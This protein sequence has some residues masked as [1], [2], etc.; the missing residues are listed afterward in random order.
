ME[1]D[2]YRFV[3][4]VK[5]NLRS[6]VF[7]DRRVPF[8]ET[9][10][11]LPTD[12]LLRHD[13]RILDPSTAAQP[14]L[15]RRQVDNKDLGKTVRPGSRTS[16]PLMSAIRFSPRRRGGAQTGFASSPRAQRG[17]AE[18]AELPER[19]GRAPA[20]RAGRSR[21]DR[22]ARSL[23][24]PSCRPP[25]HR[26]R[27][28]DAASRLADRTNP[29]RQPAPAAG[30]LGGRPASAGRSGRFS[31]RDRPESPDVRL[32]AGRC[33]IHRRALG[34]RH[35]LHGGPRDRGQRVRHSRDGWPGAGALARPPA[36]ANRG[37]PPSGCR[38][39]RHGSRHPSLVRGARR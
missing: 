5:P 15:E 2:P 10:I 27:V 16:R 35:R 8:K 19:M 13:A 29:P 11:L 25:D 9:P 21:A 32:G 30:C 20:A 7:P 22:S 28:A 38:H 6:K 17:V 1:Q 37:R 33:G 23:P 14:N 36:A 26:L 24:V 39:P 31:R 34:R 18:A 3:W 12:V 4:P